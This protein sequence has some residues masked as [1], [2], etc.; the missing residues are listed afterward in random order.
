MRVDASLF[1]GASP[2][3]P[4]GLLRVLPLGIMKA[5]WVINICI[6]VLRHYIGLALLVYLFLYSSFRASLLDVAIE[7]MYLQTRDQ[8]T[9]HRKQETGNRQITGSP[10]CKDSTLARMTVSGT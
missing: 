2:P 4:P 10:F 7:P 3:T 5:L 1:F 6:K 8:P 9:G